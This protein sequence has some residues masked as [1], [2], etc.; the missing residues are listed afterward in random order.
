MDPWHRNAR[1]RAAGD[2]PSRPQ[3]VDQPS[4]GGV[5]D[6]ILRDHNISAVTDQAGHALLLRP[7]SVVVDAPK[8]DTR[9]RLSATLPKLVPGA[10]A[11]FADD[12]LAIVTL[13]VVR[14]RSGGR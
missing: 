1:T 12:D 6:G 11:E 2:P 9:N 14:R 3:A 8:G 5:L 7:N 10:R 4:A 13:P